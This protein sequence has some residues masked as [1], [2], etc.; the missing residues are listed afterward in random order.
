MAYQ[1]FGGGKHKC[2]GN[3]FAIFQIK[4]IFAVLLRRFEFELADSPEH[5]RDDYT[6][7]IVQPAS[8]CRVRYRLRSDTP[9]GHGHS[10]QAAA[11]AP[12]TPP[13]AC[14]MHGANATNTE[15]A[16]AGF[17]PENGENTLKNSPKTWQIVHDAQLCQG[18]AVC[19]GEAPDYFF[20][21][22]QSKLHIK[23]VSVAAGDEEKV[24]RAVRYCPNGALKLQ[25]MEMPHH[26]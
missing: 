8:P 14:P 13:A 23:Q 7:M 12:Q 10:G 5:Y 6:Q 2:S 22:A 17:T 1:P 15:A 16:E 21:D 19:Q 26:D 25:E 4:A 9:V 11:S 3:S 24:R 18:H 20:V